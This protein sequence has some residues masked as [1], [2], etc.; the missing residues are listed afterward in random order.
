LAKRGG[1]EDTEVHCFFDVAE[2]IKTRKP[3][4]FSE[5]VIQ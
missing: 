5:N 1:F 4:A 2:I 3:K